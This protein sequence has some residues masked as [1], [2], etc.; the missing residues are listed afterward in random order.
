MARHLEKWLADHHHVQASAKNKPPCV[1]ATVFALAK[2]NCS[3]FFFGIFLSPL[4]SIVASERSSQQ[5]FFL[6]GRFLYFSLSLSA[7][8][9]THPTIHIHKL[10]KFLSYSFTATITTLWEMAP[11]FAFLITSSHHTNTTYEALL[12]WFPY[13]NP[14]LGILRIIMKVICSTYLV[15]FSSYQTHTYTH[16]QKK[17]RSS[18][19]DTLIH[20]RRTV[21]WRAM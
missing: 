9:L 21:V 19:R 5:M 18:F 2:H 12:L 3:F 14:L 4:E 20:Y 11:F 17:E 7:A 13:I 16:R 10:P 15:L 1:I 8:I 6:R